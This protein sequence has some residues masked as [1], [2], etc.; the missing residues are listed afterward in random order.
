MA[1]PPGDLRDPV[2]GRLGMERRYFI[3][4]CSLVTGEQTRSVQTGLGARGT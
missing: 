2:T 1:E 4:L 3:V